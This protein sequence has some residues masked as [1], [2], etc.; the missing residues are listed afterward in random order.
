MKRKRTHNLMKYKIERTSDALTVD[1]ESYFQVL[2]LRIWVTSLEGE[3][4]N[5]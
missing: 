3:L 1:F 4:E 2:L 5:D